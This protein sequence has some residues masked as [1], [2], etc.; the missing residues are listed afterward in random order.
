MKT[1]TLFSRSSV[2]AS[3]GFSSLAAL[4]LATAALKRMARGGADLDDPLFGDGPDSFVSEVGTSR[5]RKRGKLTNS[6]Q[7]LFGLDTGA[8]GALLAGRWTPDLPGEEAHP[9]R[10]WLAASLL[11][12][13]R[14]L[15]T[16]QVDC[17]PPDGDGVEQE[18]LLTLELGT[19]K[20][21][22]YPALLAKLQAY[23]LFRPRD[24]A[25]LSALRSRALEWV[26]ARGLEWYDVTLALPPTVALAFRASAQEESSRALLGEG[27]LLNPYIKSRGS[28]VN[29]A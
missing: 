20:C 8:L 14:V 22:V 12:G 7:R 29:C 25:L 19:T 26:R 27:S 13:A 24:A 6:L 16:T 15:G 23:A 3:L 18:T 17:V 4:L 11:D 2:Y 28:L 9:L 5:L 1:R 21:R 10:K